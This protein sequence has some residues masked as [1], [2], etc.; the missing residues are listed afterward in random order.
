MKLCGAEILFFFLLR[1]VPSCSFNDN[2]W[3]YLKLYL[4]SLINKK[5]CILI[6]G[7]TEAEQFNINGPAKLEKEKSMWTQPYTKSCSN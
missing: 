7:G 6:H 5:A 1:V 4:L 2:Q 3:I